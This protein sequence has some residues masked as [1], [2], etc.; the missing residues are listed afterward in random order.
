MSAVRRAYFICG[1]DDHRADAPCGYY[2]VKRHAKALLLT[3]EEAATIADYLNG[4]HD[5]LPLES[6]PSD[7]SEGGC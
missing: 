7:G 3:P 2:S 6:L 4:V 1:L 5:L